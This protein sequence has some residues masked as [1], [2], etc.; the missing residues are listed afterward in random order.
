MVEI[1]PMTINERRKYVYKMWERY[2][3]ASRKEKGRLLDEMQAVTGLHRKSLIR[4]LTGRLSRQKRRRERGRTYGAEVEDVVRV[5]ARSLDY[6]CAERLKPALVP[7]A[8]HL[9]RQGEV[10]VTPQTLERLGQVSVSTL[11]RM[12]KRLG[13]SEAKLAYRKP[14]R[15]PRPSLR[16]AY[17]MRRIAWDVAAAGHF[18]VD[19]VVHSDEDTRGD[20]IHT[21]Q[22]VDVKTGWSELEAVYGRSYLAMRDG[23]EAILRRLPFPIRELHPD[24]GSE[25]FNAHLLRF[26]QSRIPALVISRSRPYHKNDNRFVEENNHSLVR[27]Y[28]GHGRL[29]RLEQLFLLRQLYAAL[30]LYHNFFQP[31]M[32]TQHKI[33]QDEQHYRRVF[34]TPKTPFERLCEV[35]TLPPAVLAQLQ[36]LRDQTNPLHLRQQIAD[37]IDQLWAVPSHHP[38]QPVNVYQTLRKEPDPSVTFSFELITPPR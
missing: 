35:E 38:A 20:V 17:P 14:P 4:I 23:F 12:L 2:R 36:A 18:E 33:R 15:R 27:A 6:P 10:Q 30:W 1:E 3:H 7:L 13:R 29:D 25:F 5:V 9:E 19:L 31:V 8:R 22:M 34:D 16:H 11:K 24:N 37:L 21:L 32:R 28:V 26:W